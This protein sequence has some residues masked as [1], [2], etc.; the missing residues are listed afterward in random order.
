MDLTPRAPEPVKGFNLEK[1]TRIASVRF[2]SLAMEKR[3]ICFFFFLKGNL[4]GIIQNSNMEHRDKK[5]KL[6][7]LKKP[8]R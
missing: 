1:D 8:N 3:I 2:S 7:V 6:S 4:L 5:D